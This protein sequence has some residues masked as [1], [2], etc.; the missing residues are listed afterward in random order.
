MMVSRPFSVSSIKILLEAAPALLDYI[1]T[2]G[3]RED[4]EGPLFLP[5]ITSC[6]N[7]ASGAR[8]NNRKGHRL[9][10]RPDSSERR[11]AQYEFQQ[12]ET[13]RSNPQKR[14]TRKTLNLVGR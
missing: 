5:L 13:P 10:R 2:A 14:Q 4:K 9:N 11:H 7:R 12:Y 3:I 8:R 6:P 1:E